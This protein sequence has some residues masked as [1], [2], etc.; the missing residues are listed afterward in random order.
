M[1]IVYLGTPKASWTSLFKKREAK[2]PSY[3]IEQGFSPWVGATS[4][5]LG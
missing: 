4:V 5:A 1:V 2:A 3:P